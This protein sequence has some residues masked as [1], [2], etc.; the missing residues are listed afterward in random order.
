MG[1]P[2]DEPFREPGEALRAV[3]ISRGLAVASHPV[4]QGLWARLWGESGGR[5]PAE[6]P[7]ERVSWW[8]A[9]AFC[10]A[11]SNAAGRTP[12]YS[13]LDLELTCNFDAD[14]YRLPTEAEWE[15]VARAG[16]TAAFVLGDAEEELNRLAWYEANSGSVLHPVGE[17][18]PNPWGL[19]DVLGNVWEWCWDWSGDYTNGELLDPTGPGLGSDRVVRGGSCRR[20]AAH[21]RVAH[22]YY[23]PPNNRGRS[24]GFRVVRSVALEPT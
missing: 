22:R 7:L 24:I 11:L 9:I 18:E 13:F 3:Q 19:Y 6:L 20:P 8:D 23:S 10:N 14:G 17:K 4:N 16:T 15:Y 12:C 5:N 21:C 1:S 2:N